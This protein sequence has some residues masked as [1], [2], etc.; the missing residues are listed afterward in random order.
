[1]LTV[2]KKQVGDFSI[3]EMTGRITLGRECQQVEWAVDDLLK[4]NAKKIVLDLSNV[5]FLDS[6]GIGIIV[7]CAGKSKVAKSEL[8]V[9]GAKGLVEQTLQL[10]NVDKIIPMHADTDAAMNW[11]RAKAA[12]L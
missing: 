2:E 6:T 11:S 1:M 9:A 8:I 3:V 4:E 10:T 5:N 12:A 7:M